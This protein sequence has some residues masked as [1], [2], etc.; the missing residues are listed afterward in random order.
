LI[1]A[2]QQA[3]AEAD[4]AAAALE[5]WSQRQN[6][7][8]QIRDT[9]RA[10]IGELRP[11]RMELLAEL[12]LRKSRPSA[13]RMGPFERYPD[14]ALG[15]E[16]LTGL[17]SERPPTAP[18][19]LEQGLSGSVSGRRLSDALL[20]GDRSRLPQPLPESPRGSHQR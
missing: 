17:M 13:A 3:Q 15:W 19:S 20:A 11:R 2:I 1:A 14:K 4:A 10:R 5:R 12:L 16:E 18:P 7:L 6:E 8:Q 9:A